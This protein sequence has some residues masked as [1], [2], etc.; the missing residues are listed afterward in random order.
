MKR[1]RSWQG[2]EDTTGRCRAAGIHL[3]RVPAGC[4]NAQRQQSMLLLYRSVVGWLLTPGELAACHAP[5]ACACVRVEQKRSISYSFRTT[6]TV[7]LHCL[8]RQI[9][10]FYAGLTTWLGGGHGQSQDRD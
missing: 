5:P 2:L 6:D 7:P 1:D 10:R 3:W 9:P 4:G 8:D